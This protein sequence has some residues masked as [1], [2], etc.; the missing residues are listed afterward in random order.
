MFLREVRLSDAREIA[1]IYNRCILHTTITFEK[2]PVSV[3]SM[4]NRIRELS[5]RAPYF[6]CEIDGHVAGYCYAHVWKGKEAYSRTLETTVYVGE[7][8]R[9][10]GVGRALMERLVSACREAGVHVLVACI[11][12][13]NEASIH[14]HE[15]LGF[16]KVSHFHEV[17]YKFGRWIDIEDYELL[18]GQVA[19]PVKIQP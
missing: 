15:S 9:R 6:V 7:D 16:R 19:I 12:E 4:E 13:G 14:L 17:G 2:E 1:G 5:L 18:L 11:T 10:S 3:E 8:Y